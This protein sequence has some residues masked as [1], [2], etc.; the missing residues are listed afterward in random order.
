MNVCLKPG[1]SPEAK[2]RLEQGAPF[3]SL[4]MRVLE[5][6]GCGGRGAFTTP[7]CSG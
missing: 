1:S 6:A 4:A 3:P 5:Q 7:Q 2:A